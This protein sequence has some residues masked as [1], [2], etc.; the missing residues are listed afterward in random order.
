MAVVIW[1]KICYCNCIYTILGVLGLYQYIYYDTLYYIKHPPHPPRHNYT[2]LFPILSD[3][4]SVIIVMSNCCFVK[5]R[6]WVRIDCKNSLFI[7]RTTII[8]KSLSVISMWTS[9]MTYF[10]IEL[11]RSQITELVEKM[12][13]WIQLPLVESYHIFYSQDQAR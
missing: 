9:I 3:Q 6:K 13:L 7:H 4:M 8:S 5:W 1:T 10:P 2:K 11:Q 12:H